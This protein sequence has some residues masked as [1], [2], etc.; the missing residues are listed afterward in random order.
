MKTLSPACGNICRQRCYHELEARHQTI[1]ESFAKDGIYWPRALIHFLQFLKENFE[2]L[3][4]L[5]NVLFKQSFF[6]KNI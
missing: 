6:I 1:H 4:V 5:D 3:I 2:F